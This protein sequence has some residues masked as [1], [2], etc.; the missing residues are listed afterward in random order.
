MDKLYT[1]DEIAE[2]LSVKKTTVY[3]WIRKKKLPAVCFGKQY[4]VTESDVEWF[5]NKSRTFKRE[6]TEN[7]GVS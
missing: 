2:M 7:E 1:C 4:F 5:I 3:D 6:D